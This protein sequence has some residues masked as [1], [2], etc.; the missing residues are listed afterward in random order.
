MFP[1]YILQ[2]SYFLIIIIRRLKI[3]ISLKYLK[4]RKGLC[5]EKIREFV[6]VVGSYMV[7]L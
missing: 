7:D 2:S 4:I 6:P 3:K 5:Y 1:L